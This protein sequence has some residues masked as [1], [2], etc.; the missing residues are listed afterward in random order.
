[1]ESSLNSYPQEFFQFNIGQSNNYK[2]LN[3]LILLPPNFS[4]WRTE[5]FGR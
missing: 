1:M 3:S 5:T 2:K 4:L